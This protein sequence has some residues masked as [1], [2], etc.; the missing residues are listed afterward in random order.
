[1]PD[2]RRSSIQPKFARSQSFWRASGGRWLLRGAAAGVLSLVL[3]PL[4]Y[5]VVR[6]SEAGPAALQLL[7]EA[8]TMRVLARSAALALAVPLASAILAVPL[9]WLTTRTDLPL[10]KMWAVLT[11]LP[12]VI[13]SY[14]FA[15]LLVSVLGPRGLLQQLLQPLGV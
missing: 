8:R 6:A 15:Y 11:A 9:A 14:I 7:V 4:I 10:R 5:L 13:P 2:Q 12:L 1:M 3:L